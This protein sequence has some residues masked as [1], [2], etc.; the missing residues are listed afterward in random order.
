MRIAGNEFGKE[1]RR[2]R[3]KGE[4]RYSQAQLAELAGIT[5]SYVSQLETGVRNPTHRV[6]K[7]LS[8]VLGVR[9]NQLLSTVGLVEFSMPV[10]LAE[11]RE[12]AI[13]ILDKLSEDEMEE[14]A[15]FLSYLKFKRE[16]LR[17]ELEPADG[18]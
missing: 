7:R 9:P 14:L 4:K 11:K 5:P 8:A 10:S 13:S 18:M 15:D 3:T 16:I 1:L 6:I 2:L 12:Y 17:A